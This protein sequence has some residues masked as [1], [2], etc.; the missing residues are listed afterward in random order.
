MGNLIAVG[1]ES[2]NLGDSLGDVAD[3]YEQETNEAIRTMSNL[4]EP[5]MILG[6]GLVIGFIVFAM[7]LPIFQ[8]DVFAR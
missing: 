1:E 4:F 7:L 5:L 6:V 8:I 3:S 2:G